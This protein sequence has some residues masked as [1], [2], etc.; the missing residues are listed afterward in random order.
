MLNVIPFSVVKIGICNMFMLYKPI[1][2]SARSWATLHHVAPNRRI[3]SPVLHDVNNMET[4]PEAF[5][6]SSE[7]YEPN[8]LRSPRCHF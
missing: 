4:K 8:I 3:P 1:N 6:Y 5:S 7:P 2:S